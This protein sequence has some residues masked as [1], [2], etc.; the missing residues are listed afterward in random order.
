MAYTAD[1]GEK[2][3]EIQ[4]GLKGGMSPPMTWQLDGKQ[5]I[6][7][8]GGNG[9]VVGRNVEPGTPLPV[10]TASTVFPKMLT[11]VLDG[12]PMPVP[13]APAAPAAN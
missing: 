8:M 10:A 7:L 3:L 9:L 2:V 4:T 1:K 6:T 12:T 11:F 5:Y 13:V